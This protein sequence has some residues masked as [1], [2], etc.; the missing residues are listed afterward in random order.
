MA[1]ISDI[2]IISDRNRA[3]IPHVSDPIITIRMADFVV[4]KLPHV[5]GVSIKVISSRRLKRNK[6]GPKSKANLGALGC[7]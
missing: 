7:R 3:K 2:P 1:M 4:A 5:I 6:K